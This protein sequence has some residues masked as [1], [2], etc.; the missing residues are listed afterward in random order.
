MTRFH[1]SAGALNSKA[2]IFTLLIAINRALSHAPSA[3][4]EAFSSVSVCRETIVELERPCQ[5]TRTWS[6]AQHCSDLQRLSTHAEQK[7]L[8]IKFDYR[9]QRPLISSLAEQEIYPRNVTGCGRGG[10]HS[11]ITQFYSCCC[12]CQ[13][14]SVCIRG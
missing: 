2:D 4:A 3:L 8:C 6:E 10:K 7:L 5:S 13:I 9:S 1:C 14:L 12:F 11:F